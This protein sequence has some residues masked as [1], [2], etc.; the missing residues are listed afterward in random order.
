MGV[1][2]DLF[3]LAGSLVFARISLLLI[4]TST[5]LDSSGTGAGV[6]GVGVVVVVL[7]AGSDG[8]CA[9][10]ALNSRPSLSVKVS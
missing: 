9:G 1:L 6:A 2:L 8:G 10:A 4:I 3:L 5:V 7:L